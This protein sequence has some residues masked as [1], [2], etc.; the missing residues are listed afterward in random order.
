MSQPT[1][2]VLVSNSSFKPT[3]SF[4]RPFDLKDDQGSWQRRPHRLGANLNITDGGEQ[5]QQKRDQ[6]LSIPCLETLAT[7]VE[8][9]TFLPPTARAPAST[10]SIYTFPNGNYVTIPATNDVQA[11][12]SYIRRFIKNFVASPSRRPHPELKETA[13]LAGNTSLVD[14]LNRGQE[15]HLD[16]S[17]VMDVVIFVCGHGNRDQRCGILGPLLLAELEQKLPKF[18]VNVVE[19]GAGKQTSI[20]NRRSKSDPTKENN[21]SARVGLISHIGGHKWAGNLI[22][23]FPRYYQGHPQA[24]H[25]LKGKGIWYGRVEPWHVE[26]IIEQTIKEGTIIRELFRG[27]MPGVR[28]SEGG[29]LEAAE[30]GQ[31]LAPILPTPWVPKGTR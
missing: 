13:A 6:A 28:L 3:P 27:G 17:S 7:N 2:S 24:K 26:G 5:A 30:E 4:S 8:T 10:T 19:S 22:I 23:Y 14:H 9:R 29:E 11:Y 1:Q 18:G 16:R 21:M 12:Y 25:P 15:F 31:A 20:R